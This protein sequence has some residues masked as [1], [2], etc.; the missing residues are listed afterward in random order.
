LL[1][2]GIPNFKL[3]KHVVDR[4][5]QQLVAEGVEF[6]TNAHVGVNVQ[7]ERLRKEYDA[8]LLAGG[9]EQPR[10]LQVP[11]RELKGI[12]YAMEFLPQQNRRNEGD[13]VEDSS[14]I[15]A[16][17]KHVVI[18][19]GGDTGA[20]CLGTSHRQLPKVGAAVRNYADPAE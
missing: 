16:T 20:D 7:V 8:V 19:G 6:V 3:E 10:D 18:I 14:S 2:Y 12:H 17:G 13:I 5:V 9:A 15:L 11:G 1:R 4:R